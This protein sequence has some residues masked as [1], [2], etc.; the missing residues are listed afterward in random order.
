MPLSS[1]DWSVVVAGSWNR[2]ILTPAGIQGRIFQLAADAPV[3][4][5][6]PI[7]VLAPFQV[8]HDGF[9]VAVHSSRLVVALTEPTFERLFQ[10]QTFARNAINSLPETPYFG[11]GINIGFASNDAVPEIDNLLSE[12]EFDDRLADNEL[13]ISGRRFGRQLVWN[14]GKVNLNVSRDEGDNRKV[15]LNIERTSTNNQELIGWLET[16]S[17]QIEELVQT[18]S[19]ET[20]ELE[21]PQNDQEEN[22]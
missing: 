2:A 1:S 20:L 12:N 4:V 21:L 14:D 9:S 19:N 8:T 15:S 13:H 10:A 5:M 6:V 7:D 18:I 22:N 17:Q 11:V 16:P 3:E